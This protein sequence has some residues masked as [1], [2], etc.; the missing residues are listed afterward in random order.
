MVFAFGAAALL[1]LCA[2]A[3]VS[4]SSAQT[5]LLDVDFALVPYEDFSQRPLGPEDKL[6][7]VPVRLVLSRQSD[8]QAPDA[9]IR[10]I[11]D[12][13]GRA[14]FTTSG[15]VDLSW[16]AVNAGFTGFPVFKHSPHIWIAAELEQLV[17]RSAGGYDR[18]QWLHTMEIH[19]VTESDCSTTGIGEVYARDGEGRFTLAGKRR[20]NEG[21]LRMPDVANHVLA[22]PGYDTS[23]LFLSTDDPGQRRWKLSITL[24]RKPAPVL[25]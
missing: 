11:T 12:E 10:F 23:G 15:T 22:G 7:G 5:V 25:S 3:F 8:W 19:C 2:A 13:H 20:G 9:G 18:H 14:R 4:R 24:R 16:Q 21:G 1:M 6:A 17:P